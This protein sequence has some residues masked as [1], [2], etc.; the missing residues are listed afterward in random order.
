MDSK[1]AE[2]NCLLAV[3][4]SVLRRFRVIVVELHWLDLLGSA[5]FLNQRVL[6]MLHML[7]PDFGCVHA[8]ANNCCGIVVLGFVTVPRVLELTY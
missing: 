1:G 7:D 2:Q 8:D 4:E 5:R 6:P 3:S